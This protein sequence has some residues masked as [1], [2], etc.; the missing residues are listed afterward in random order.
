MSG[1]IGRGAYWVSMVVGASEVEAAVD[2]LGAINL[3]IIVCRPVLSRI[4]MVWRQKGNMKKY[5]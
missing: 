1:V 5:Q 3:E 2:D 4:A